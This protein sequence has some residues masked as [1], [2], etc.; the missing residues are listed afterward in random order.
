MTISA[1][2][3]QDRSWL[4]ADLPLVEYGETRD[5]QVCLVAARKSGILSSDVLLL[6]QH[7]PVF[8]LGRRG[9]RENL[10]VSEEF[11]R[12]SGV[13]I[14]H[15]ERG[16]DIT[17]H[18]PGQLVGYPIVDLQAAG[19]SVTAYV[20]GLEEIMIRTAAHFGVRAGRSPLNRGVWVGNSKLG[21]IGIAIRRG[22]AFHGFAFNVNLSLEPF[23]WINPCGL[24]GITMTSLQ[25]ELSREVPMIEV[26]EQMKR[27][28]E[29]VFQVKLRQLGAPSCALSCMGLFASG[30]GLNG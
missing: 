3:T 24:H 7:A 21:S 9:G 1:P 8:T 14:V 27:N 12:R 19:L 28:I 4:C 11:L 6:L 23:G 20:E 26:R 17:Y 15:V 30:V 2:R 29:E 13:P 5:L 10:K 16:G 18:G 25:R 22:I